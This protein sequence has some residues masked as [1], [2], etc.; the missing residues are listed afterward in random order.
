MAWPRRVILAKH[1]FDRGRDVSAL[2]I[3]AGEWQPALFHLSA[4]LAEYFQPRPARM[5]ALGELV[6]IINPHTAINVLLHDSSVSAGSM[7]VRLG[8][9]QLGVR[10]KCSP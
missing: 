10:F 6:E 4:I 9:G 8:A 7:S 3:D 1:Y 2:K 5:I